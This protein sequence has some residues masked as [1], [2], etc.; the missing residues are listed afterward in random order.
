M[1]GP[2]NPLSEYHVEDAILGT[3]QQPIVLFGLEINHCKWTFCKFL[4][5]NFKLCKG[6]F[7]SNTSV[8]I[9]IKTCIVGGQDLNKLLA[10]SRQ[11]REDDF[12][13]A[14]DGVC[15]PYVI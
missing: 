7:C 6:H 4:K 3:V 2:N 15:R 14:V 1:F 10:Y 13:Q 9:T 8:N 5:N 12:L 11:R